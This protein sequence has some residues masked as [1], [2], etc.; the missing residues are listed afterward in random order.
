MKN[1]FKVA[2]IT[3]GLLSLFSCE[4]D[5]K[6][7]QLPSAAALTSPENAATE[8]A[9]LPTLTWVKSI[10]PDNDIVSYNVYVSELEE[11]VADDR[12]GENLSENTYTLKTALKP[13]TKYFWKV[14]AS[15]EDGGS[16]ESEV[17]YF[18]T[19]NSAPAISGLEFPANDA[20]DVEKSISLKWL[21]ADADGDVL[22]YTVY[23][24]KE[25]VFTVDNIVATDITESEFAVNLDGH[26]QYFWKLVAKDTEGAKIESDVASFTTMNTLP[27]KPVLSSPV[28]EFDQVS[29]ETKISWAAAT[30]ADGDA[31][32]YTVFYGT[33]AEINE[34][35][36]Y[37]KDFTETEL[38]LSNLRGNTTYYWKVV[39]FDSEEGKM[40]SDVFSF[41]TINTIP[42]A[43]VLSA[44]IDQSIV[45]EKLNVIINWSA[46]IDPDK[47][48]DSEGN[49]I[50]EPL[51][52][53]VY[54]SSDE[55]IEESELKQ[56]DVS[57]PTFTFEGLEFAT[58]YFAK[59]VTRDPQN[60][61]SESEVVEFTTKEKPDVMEGTWTDTRDGKEYKTITVAGKTW[62]AENYA[63]IP[64]VIQG[65]KACAVY[66]IDVTESTTASDLK[67]EDNFDKYG[68]MYNAYALEDLAPAGWHV[69]TDDD[70]KAISIFAGMSQ[71]EADAT[72]SQYDYAEKFLD[73][74]AGWTNLEKATNDFLFSVVD[75]GYY[76]KK[77]YAFIPGPEYSY[78]GSGMYSY[79]W[80]N[81][82]NVDNTSYFFRAFS[83]TSNYVQR[84]SNK[85]SNT[86]MY[87][88]LVKD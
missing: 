78:K 70:W 55:T 68:V 63:Y 37:K 6:E 28:N 10:D 50:P 52:Y 48:R 31:V 13:H 2:L 39:A 45:D 11:F 12:M 76:V 22:K 38:M 56:K 83:G 17:R 67:A 27:S 87:V 88:R 79:Y 41:S 80:T 43:P 14:V 33:N 46:S 53:D 20:I 58:K 49:L 77:K 64:Y 29:L 1:Y 44:E 73:P 51:M 25:N 82:T 19:M 4:D 26:S 15:D 23:L 57:D 72:G 5:D 85:P 7:N 42:T 71:A 8:L 66:G 84:D 86:R 18:S 62:L 32:S 60:A 34:N 40:S 9:T 74:N 65:D 24:S 59:I 21:A 35:F 36:P 61:K 30:D 3:L 47:A 69:A 16:S 75:G 81:T 54:L